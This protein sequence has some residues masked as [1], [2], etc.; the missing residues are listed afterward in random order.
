MQDLTLSTTSPEPTRLRLGLVLSL[1]VH[2]ILL[3]MSF[4]GHV[5]A[6]SGFGLFWQDRPTNIPDMQVILL[7]TAIPP[8]EPLLAVPPDQPERKSEPQQTLSNEVIALAKSDNPAWIV[9][10]ASKAPE[11]PTPVTALAIPAP[12]EATDLKQEAQRQSERIEAAQIENAKQADIQQEKIRLNA[13]RLELIKVEAARAE[14]ER[15]EIATQTAARQATARQEAMRQEIARTE[16]ARIDAERQELEKK[17]TAQKLATLQEATRAE[18]NRAEAERKEVS[19]QETAKIA[20]QQE[21]T[22][23]ETIRAEA[24]RMEAAK[25]EIAKQVA[26]KQAAARQE[27]LRQ[28]AARTDA[29]RIDAERLEITKKVAA[30]L[31]ATQQETAK[32]DIA[33]A[34]VARAEAIRAGAAKLEA[35]RQEAVKQVAATQEAA[36]Q[37]LIQ[38]ESKR[39]AAL[40]AEAQQRQEKLLAIGR[41]LN[42]EAKQRDAAAQRQLASGSTAR[43]GRIMG[44]NDPNAELLLYAETWSRKIQMNTTLDNVLTTAKQPHTNP[45]VTVAIR[46]DGS[47]ESI[48]FVVSSGVPAIDEAIRRIVQSQANYQTFPPGLVKDFDVIDIRRTWYFDMAIRLY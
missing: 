15:L 18:A 46:S 27:V 19:R 28:E 22:R 47:V 36:R 29:A 7:P 45:M 16:A 34:E 40:Q 37:A 2:A 21:A 25:I 8:A 39:L 44:R 4:G 30:Q 35:E 42:E 31:L 9:P 41:Q 3:A 23:L 1:T 24:A 48:T 5:P 17:A 20:A 11:A 10:P 14:A 6:L 43:R 12:L 26:E 32:A 38:I 13:A 33:R